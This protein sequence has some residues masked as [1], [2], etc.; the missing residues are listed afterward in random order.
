ME[1][2]IEFLYDKKKQRQ[3]MGKQKEKE[4]LQRKAMKKNK[5]L[6]QNQP[7]VDMQ[8]KPLEMEEETQQP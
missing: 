7:D 6:Y 1:K 3:E 5:D 8:L 2:N 4:A